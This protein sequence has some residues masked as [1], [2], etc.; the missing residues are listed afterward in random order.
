MVKANLISNHTFGL[1]STELENN[2][3]GITSTGEFQVNLDGKKMLIL[4]NS[5]ATTSRQILENPT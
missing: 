2:D 1:V 3:L 5:R 4:A